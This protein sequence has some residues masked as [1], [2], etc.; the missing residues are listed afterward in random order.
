MPPSAYAG[1]G[2]PLYPDNSAYCVVTTVNPN[3]KLITSRYYYW[4]VGKTSLEPES[5]HQSTVSTIADVIANPQSQA[6][7]YAAAIRDDTISLYGITDYLTGNTV[8]LHTE[9]DTL[10]NTSIIHSEY[11]LIGEGNTNS[12]IPARIVNKIIELLQAYNTKI[13]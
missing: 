7:P 13:P 11:Q 6:I 2:T 10:K 1:T 5:I 3:T 12:K 4:V 9:Y 8:V